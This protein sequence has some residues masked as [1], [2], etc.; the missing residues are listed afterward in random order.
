[1]RQFSPVLCLILAVGCG[2]D[3]V[4]L[5]PPAEKLEI[6][7]PRSQE[8]LRYTVESTTGTLGFDMEAPLEKIRGRVPASALSGEILFDPSDITKTTGLLHVDL[9][10]LELF[11]QV[12]SDDGATFAEET[13]SDTQNQHAR[14]WLEIGPD[15]P[16]DQLVKNAKIEFSLLE[17][18][19][20]S[21]TDT[22]PLP[23]LLSATCSCT[24]ARPP[25]R[26]NLR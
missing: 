22:R 25:S 16:E 9:R 5:A 10:E 23:A 1:M 12:S 21:A 7:A 24:N 17:V 20:A 26:S 11:Q 19:D 18:R 13:K 2:G 8:V 4:P 14:D 6:A 15:T 3:P